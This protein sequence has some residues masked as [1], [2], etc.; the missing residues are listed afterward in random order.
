MGQ[1]SKFIVLSSKLRVQD[2]G[3]LRRGVLM[4]TTGFFRDRSYRFK[5]YWQRID[6]QIK[7]E[8]IKH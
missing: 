5:P 1:G 3:V 8:K 6:Q 4:E 7:I 2:N